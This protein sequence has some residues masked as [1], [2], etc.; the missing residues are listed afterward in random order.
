L[1]NTGNLNLAGLQVV[2]DLRNQ[3]GFKLPKG[4]KLPVYYD[5]QYIN[6]AKAK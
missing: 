5:A 6:A 2:L 4:D 3:F 1:S